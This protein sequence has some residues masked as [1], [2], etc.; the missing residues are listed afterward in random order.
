[1]Y[2]QLLY[3]CRDCHRSSA[4]YSTIRRLL[5]IRPITLTIPTYICQSS[6]LLPVTGREEFFSTQD[7][8][9]MYTNNR[10]TSNDVHKSCIA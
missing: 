3:I 7:L 8:V 4:E 5:H 9:A 6:L 1:M 2:I 10:R